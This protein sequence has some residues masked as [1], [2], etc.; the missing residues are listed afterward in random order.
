MKKIS[1][2]DFLE[3]SSVCTDQKDY[4]CLPVSECKISKCKTEEKSEDNLGI[5]SGNLSSDIYL[6]IQ[7]VSLS[8]SIQIVESSKTVDFKGFNTTVRILVTVTTSTIAWC[9]QTSEIKG[10]YCT[11]SQVRA[12]H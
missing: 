12:H 11:E 2:F 10:N 7:H 9:T 4:L 6:K 3:S 1:F 5:R 8:L